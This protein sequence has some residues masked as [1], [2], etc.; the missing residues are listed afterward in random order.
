MEPTDQQRNIIEYD[1]NSVVMATPGS[2]KTYVLSEKIKN[3]IRNLKD[4]EGVIAISYTN[5]ASNE[6]KFRAL[7]RGL[8]PKS[9]FFGTIDKFYISQIII[10]FGKQL[11]GLPKTPIEVVKKETLTEHEQELIPWLTEKREIILEE[12]SVDQLNAL[13]KYFFNGI[14]ILES[15]GILAN[16]LFTNS[17]SCRRYIQSR[18]RYIFIDEYQDSGINQHE[19]FSKIVELGI[20]GFAV[21]D[22][23]QSIFRFSGRDSRFLSELTTYPT[24]SVF[25]LNINHRCH[26]SIINYSN[27]LLGLT[28]DL[29]EVDRVNMFFIRI[30][31]KEENVAD[32]ISE[33]IRP[34]KNFYHV[35]NQSELAILCVSNRTAK[36]ISDNLNLPNKL[37]ITTDLEKSLNVWSSVFVQLLLFANDEKFRFIE[38][39][40]HFTDF[41][42]F[43]KSKRSKLVDSERKI[44]DLFQVHPL[45]IESI[46]STF[47]TVASIIAP[48]SFKQKSIDHLFNVLMN[49]IDLNSFRPAS[50]EEINVMTLHKAKGLEFDVVFHLDLHEWIL[51][52]KA[53]G[54]NENWKHPIFADWTQDTNTHYV[55]IT[56]ARKACVLISSTERTNK[57][58]L[59]KS[60]NDSEFL[61][62]AGISNLRINMNG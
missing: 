29:Y 9:S 37:S 32:W 11:F 50:T 61:H 34:I 18:Y 12:F 53:P 19:I 49:P 48:N 35:E 45:N 57:N 60:G 7:G 26:P 52:R 40:E 2:G 24:F 43:S 10:P 23:N 51:P 1:G 27:F 8:A 28:E 31:G 30:D 22:L 38:I 58:F 62:L 14:V 46:I 4:Y 41:F 39:I 6:L 47:T 42:S 21:G 15:V 25:P 16:Y 5:K 44:R 55:G 56:R 33:K 36:L 59:I 3:S 17:Y 54:E 13:A 20:I